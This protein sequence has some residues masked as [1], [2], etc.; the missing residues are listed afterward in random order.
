M[1]GRGRNKDKRMSEKEYIVIG[2]EVRSRKDGDYHYVDAMQLCRLY[3]LDPQKAVLLEERNHFNNPAIFDSKEAKDL[4]IYRPR[5]DGKYIKRGQKPKKVV[6][7]E[8]TYTEAELIEKL[9]TLGEATA[10]FV[11]GANY[12][13]GVAG[14]YRTAILTVFLQGGELWFQSW[15]RRARVETGG[16]GH[17]KLCEV[18]W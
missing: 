13:D 5:Y 8:K 12:K 15:S 9:K 6:V 11:D 18:T 1:Q 3:G 7:G 16:R 2:S 10:Y 14:I 17:Y 4:P